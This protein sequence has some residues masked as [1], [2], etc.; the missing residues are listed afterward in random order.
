[1]SIL[2]IKY[3]QIRAKVNFSMPM[4]PLKVK[5]LTQS[6]SNTPKSTPNTPLKTE[7]MQE[8]STKKISKLQVL[9]EQIKKTKLTVLN[10][11]KKVLRMGRISLWTS[12][13]I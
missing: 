3:E 7:I 2:T 11:T 1:M 9:K 12:R 8:K 13:I 10:K 4:T 6:T 5:S